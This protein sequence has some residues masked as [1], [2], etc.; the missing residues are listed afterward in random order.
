[1]HLDISSS[2]LNILKHLCLNLK[3]YS[4]FFYCCE[5][6]LILELNF[7]MR[8]AEPKLSTKL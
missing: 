6:K 1:M 3:L 8:V 4:Y 7:Q 2:Y 5:S